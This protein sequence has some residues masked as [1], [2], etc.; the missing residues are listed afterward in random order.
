M[1]VAD[2]FLLICTLVDDL[3]DALPADCKPRG[4][5]AD[6]AYAVHLHLSAV[7]QGGRVAD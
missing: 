2:C 3:W 1:I 4:P 5:Q 6:R 7:G